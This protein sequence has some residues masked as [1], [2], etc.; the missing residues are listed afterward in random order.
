M[1]LAKKSRT[2]TKATRATAQLTPMP[3]LAAIDRPDELLL[4]GTSEPVAVAEELVVLLATGV[5]VELVPVELAAEL[6]AV[7]LAVLTGLFTMVVTKAAALFLSSESLAANRFVVGHPPELPQAF[8]E[9]H[10]KNGFLSPEAHVYHF[11]IVLEH[12]W[13]LISP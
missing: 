10:P 13:L 6:I 4:S 8:V 9:Q 11:P 12:A 2:P 7:L 5:P 1:R 3:A